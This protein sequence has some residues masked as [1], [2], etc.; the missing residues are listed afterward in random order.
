MWE[1]LKLQKLEWSQRSCQGLL[2]KVQLSV[3]IQV[4]IS[5]RKLNFQRVPYTII[6]FS[7]TP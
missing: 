5:S 6:L 3:L 1:I 2:L 7:T 4:T